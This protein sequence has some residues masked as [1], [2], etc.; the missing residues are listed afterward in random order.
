M[1]S[2]NGHLKSMQ[3]TLD[4]GPVPAEPDQA[5]PLPPSTAA[6]PLTV[7]AA[8]Q[9]RI[10]L[11]AGTRRLLSLRPVQVATGGRLFVFGQGS[12]DGEAATDTMVEILLYEQGHWRR[13]RVTGGGDGRV[14]V[15]I[16]VSD[17]EPGPVVA[18]LLTRTALEQP[19]DLLTA[20][21][22]VA[23]GARLRVGYSLEE[24]DWRGLAPFGVSV[25]VAPVGLPAQEQ[26]LLHRRVPVPAGQRWFDEEIDLSIFAGSTVRIT[27]SSWVEDS[28]ALLVPHV[29]WSIPTVVSADTAKPRK[30]VVVVAADGLR[31]DSMGCYGS[32]RDI[33]PFLDGLFTNQGVIFDR[34]LAQSDSSVAAN[35][36]LLT[37]LYPSVHGVLS[38]TRALG[39]N[40][41]TIA[42]VLRADGYATAAFTSS[43]AITAAL[44]FNR[45]FDVFWEDRDAEPWSIEQDWGRPLDA[46]LEWIKT[47]EGEPFFAFV[48]IGK[49]M[50]PHVPPRGYESLFD[51]EPAQPAD[52]LGQ[53]EVVRYHR[54][55]RYF[56]DIMA[57]FV[58]RLD[59]LSD[60]DETVLVLTSAR[61]MAFGSRSGLG[62]ELIHV[63]LMMRGGGIRSTLRYSEA[64]GII[65]VAPTVL[66]LA[67]VD[68][69]GGM[70]GQA[71]GGAL[72]LGFPF[73]LPPRFSQGR[74]Q[75]GTTTVYAVSDEDHKVLM[76]VTDGK[77]NRFMAYDLTADPDENLDLFSEGPLAPVWATDLKARLA[78]YPARCRAAALAIAEAAVL[79]M[80]VRRALAAR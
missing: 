23:E 18:A 61:G 79:P 60:P 3:L 33:T 19:A 28:E 21:F 17:L 80:H 52:N 4:P 53:G 10:G 67:G 49:A 75:D 59:A 9:T 29:V 15:T 68:I 5:E 69:P 11:R 44:G 57:A 76:E 31:V 12:S 40:T 6:A 51:D 41:P 45:G 30:S 63:P 42:S 2:E 50:P 64:I 65:D 14:A 77:A 34:A 72:R 74:L 58:S 38:H 26:E 39:E 62:E 55:L 56:N 70:Q 32:A 43:G 13:R 7:R 66:E 20:P 78:D 35:M 25:S 36:S 1:E 24:W 54:E 48:H 27:L 16:V 47:R 8:G 37:S 22:V 71:V 73:A 46:L